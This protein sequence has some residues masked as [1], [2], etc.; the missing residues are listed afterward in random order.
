MFGF[1]GLGVPPASAA[2]PLLEP[3]RLPFGLATANASFWIAGLL[4]PDR[5]RTGNAYR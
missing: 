1:G 5:G 2:T 4:L 3:G